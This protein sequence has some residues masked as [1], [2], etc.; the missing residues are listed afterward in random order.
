MGI[1]GGDVRFGGK[2]GRI[3]K[4]NAGVGNEMNTAVARE[5][6][7]LHVCAIDRALGA[8][9]VAVRSYPDQSLESL[10]DRGRL[11]CDHPGRGGHET[12]RKRGRPVV[13]R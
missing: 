2:Q 4:L 13:P 5:V 12:G 1:A 6:R 9:R 10:G 7:E 8:A 3:F 11:R